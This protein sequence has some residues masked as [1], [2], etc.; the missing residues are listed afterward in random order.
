MRIACIGV[1][2]PH[3][4]S[5][6]TTLGTV[7]EIE[8]VAFCD[9]EIE[10]REKL[11]EPMMGRPFY[12]SVEELLSREQLD[13]A[14]V[15]LPSDQATAAGMQL[16][17]AGKHLFIEKPVSRSVA[18]ATA[19]L[20]VVRERGL[21]FTTGFAW[22]FDPIARDIQ[23]LIRD[24]ALGTI[25][26]LEA[27][28]VTSSVKARNPQ[29]DVFSRERNGGGIL[30]WLAIHWLDLLRFW[31]GCE[32]ETVSALTGIVTGEAIDVEDVASMSMRFEMGAIATLHA[33]YVLP[34][35]NESFFGIR[36]SQGWIKWDADTTTLR[37]HT[38]APGI[39]DAP[40]RVIEYTRRDAP[41]YAGT[42]GRN[43]VLD[44]LH[45]IRDDRPPRVGPDELLWALRLIHAAYESSETGRAVR[46]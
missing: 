32:V 30:A 22:R 3:S 6:L 20:L 23:A 37:L 35:G 7:P 38:D 12:S 15:C 34:R 16:A 39:G 19:L 24:G 27:R 2:R 44:W 13:A 40:D 28:M 4:S 26:S 33:A 25:W 42:T 36:G 14:L 5:Y 18:E 10:R 45:A 46:P 9:P 17:G 1:N 11:P 41:G 43:M 29:S 21:K 8:V 31:M